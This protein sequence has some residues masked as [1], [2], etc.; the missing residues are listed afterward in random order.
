MPPHATLTLTFETDGGAFDI[1][2]LGDF[3]LLFRGAYAASMSSLSPLTVDEVTRTYLKIE[4]G[5]ELS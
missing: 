1:T 2:Q 3:L 4:I 5:V